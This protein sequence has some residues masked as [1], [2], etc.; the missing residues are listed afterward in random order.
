MIPAAASPIF[1]AGGGQEVGGENTT[2]AQAGLSGARGGGEADPEASTQR[3]AAALAWRRGSFCDRNNP[4][5]LRETP[6]VIF[7]AP[8]FP[9]EGEHQHREVENCFGHLTT[10]APKS[11]NPAFGKASEGGEL[12]AG[13]SLSFGGALD[14][15]QAPRGGRRMLALT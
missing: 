3:A 9:D 13:K 4:R 11:I 6:N 8:R 10:P 15:P 2:K 12:A 1:L 5:V 7:Q 14:H